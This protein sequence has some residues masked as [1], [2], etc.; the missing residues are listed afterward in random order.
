MATVERGSSK[1]ILTM[2]ARCKY[3]GE[4]R[5]REREKIRELYIW[6][7][8]CTGLWSLQYRHSG[9]W[10]LVNS[11]GARHA[12]PSTLVSRH[13]RPML[14]LNNVT[15]SHCS[16]KGAAAML[17]T[18]TSAA[19]PPPPSY[20]EALRVAG[21]LHWASRQAQHWASRHAQHWASRQHPSNT[22][23]RMCSIFSRQAISELAGKTENGRKFQIMGGKV[24]V[25]KN[26]TES[27]IQER[28]S[29]AAV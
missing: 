20:S 16:G 7:R 23:S 11:T 15:L 8:D 25:S 29:N 9:L 6:Q 18:H 5:N 28:Q 12:R 13:K 3:P 24:G 19:P 1:L 17:L 14:C 27:N 2:I 26:T 21:V 22:P 10:S 4:V